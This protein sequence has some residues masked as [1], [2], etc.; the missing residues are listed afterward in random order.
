[1]AK[2]MRFMR[3]SQNE[4]VA[5]NESVLVEESDTCAKVSSQHIVPPEMLLNTPTSWTDWFPDAVQV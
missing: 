1:M 4:I 5:V 2:V 3:P